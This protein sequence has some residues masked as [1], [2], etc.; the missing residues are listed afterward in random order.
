MLTRSG[1]LEATRLGVD[2]AQRYQSLRTPKKIWTST[3]E[4]TVKSAKSLS[5]GLADDAGEVEVVEI[6]EGKKEGADSLTPYGSCDAYSS[7][8]G[9]DQSSVSLP[10]PN[11][12]SLTSLTYSSENRSSKKC[13]LHQ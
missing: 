6:S 3:A 9:S 8:A 5:W 2:I 4:R 7:S 10:N 1:K 11:S 12:S 13:I